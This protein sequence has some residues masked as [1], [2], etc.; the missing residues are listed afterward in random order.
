MKRAFACAVGLFVLALSVAA[1]SVS[2]QP[3]SDEAV[4]HRSGFTVHS[5]SSPCANGVL[6]ATAAIP[7][8][9]NHSPGIVFSFSILAGSEPKQ[10]LDA[11]PLAMELA[12]RGNSIIV[13]ARTL[14][15]PEADKSVGTMR[16][17]VVCAEQWLSKHAAVT[18]YSWWF[19]GPE[20]DSPKLPAGLGP[21]GPKGWVVTSVGEKNSDID[22]TQHFLGET[23]EVLKWMSQNFLDSN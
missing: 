20:S 22:S 14:T 13:I 3:T 21:N 5:V 7:D 6:K 12:K 17:D 18:P 2:P 23:S 9:D 16:A 4:E 19:V 10:S 8:V 11:L 15:W 1:Q